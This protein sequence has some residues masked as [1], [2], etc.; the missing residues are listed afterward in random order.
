MALQVGVVLLIF[1]PIS[2]LLHGHPL[3]LDVQVIF[4]LT[5]IAIELVFAAPATLM[6]LAA[7]FGH[8]DSVEGSPDNAALI[9]NG[10]TIAVGRIRFQLS[11][12]YSEGN[13]SPDECVTWLIVNARPWVCCTSDYHIWGK[14][15]PTKNA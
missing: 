3:S 2:D 10:H 6:A 11:V 5:A 14:I 13:K 4:L 7:A 8:L 9:R 15:T 1:V 12:D